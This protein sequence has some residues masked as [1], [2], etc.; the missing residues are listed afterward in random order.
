[1]A[2]HNIN[3]LLNNASTKAADSK[4]R[5]TAQGG[6]AKTTEAGNSKAQQ[7]AVLLTDQAQALSKTQ[8]KLK[9]GPAINQ[10]KVDNI[11]AALAR[12]EYKID[13]QRIANKMM[14]MESDLE[15]LYK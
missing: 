11:K 8:Q 9:D 7:D 14:S 4:P 15:K 12:G 10:S 3:N 1:M 5:E 13:S 6:S 2:I